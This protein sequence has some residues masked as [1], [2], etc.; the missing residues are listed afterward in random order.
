MKIRSLAITVWYNN[1]RLLKKWKK[2]IHKLTNLPGTHHCH[3]ETV[4]S[5]RRNGKIKKA[6]LNF[7]EAKEEGEAVDDEEGVEAEDEL[8]VEEGMWMN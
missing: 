5:W 2:N 3:K 8:E 6:L 1:H 4:Y 7:V